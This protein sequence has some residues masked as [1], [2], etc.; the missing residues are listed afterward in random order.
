[1]FLVLHLNDCS[2]SECDLNHNK[3]LVN[4]PHL[5]FY[6]AS[7]FFDRSVLPLLGSRGTASSRSSRML[8]WHSIASSSWQIGGLCHSHMPFHWSQQRPAFLSTQPI[9][10]SMQSCKPSQLTSVQSAGC[11]F[12]DRF[13]QHR[14]GA[15]RSLRRNWRC[16][17][18]CARVVAQQVCHFARC[19][20][21]L[22]RC[23]SPFS[24][25]CNT[26]VPVA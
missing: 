16:A 21:A 1:M 8:R 25:A 22:D 10:L 20:H 7:L 4:I 3:E 18:L 9:R 23:V 14:Q 13:V 17:V 19:T 5:H 26:L 6:R 12:D 11:V 15:A 24:Q 2:I